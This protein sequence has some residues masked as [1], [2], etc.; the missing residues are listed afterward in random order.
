MHPLWVGAE[1]AVPSLTGIPDHPHS[2]SEQVG[3]HSWMLL[4]LKHRSNSPSLKAGQDDGDSL[5]CKAMRDQVR[6]WL[7][8]QGFS[9]PGPGAVGQQG[10][11]PWECE[12]WHRI[13]GLDREEQGLRPVGVLVQGPGAGGEDS[14]GPQGLFGPTSLCPRGHT[15]QRA[16][17][18]CI[19][20]QS[21]YRGSCLGN[22]STRPCKT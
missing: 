6:L 9:L 7:G 4:L 15:N 19:Q 2:G 10:Q 11:C 22:H 1:L 20:G 18:A 12:K 14:T 13:P 5:F 21:W 8:P 3:Q 16:R 17:Q